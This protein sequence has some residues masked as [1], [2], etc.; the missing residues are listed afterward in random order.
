MGSHERTART[1]L[2]RSVGWNPE[3]HVSRCLVRGAGRSQRKNASKNQIQDAGRFPLRTAGMC[4][5]NIETVVVAV[6]E[7][8]CSGRGDYQASRGGNYKSSQGVWFK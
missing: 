2:V 7:K 3:R 8:Q 4:L 6:P 5:V 1:E